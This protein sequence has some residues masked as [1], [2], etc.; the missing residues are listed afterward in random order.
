MCRN[1]TD[2]GSGS[3][4]KGR[5]YSVSSWQY[6]GKGTTVEQ[7]QQELRTN[8][9][10]AAGM[11][12]NSEW[13]AYNQTKGVLKASQGDSCKHINHDVNYVGWGTDDAT[14]LDYWQIRNS[15]GASWGEQGYF[16]IER[17]K[18]AFMIEEHMRAP[19]PA[20]TD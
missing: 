5:L 13:V 16:R 8:G 7:I 11:C 12:V 2:G 14:G 6:M 9:P 17:G 18:N 1:R 20:W 4:Y 3:A 15:F 10:I 19:V